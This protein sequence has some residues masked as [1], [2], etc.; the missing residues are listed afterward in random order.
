[1]TDR[2]QFEAMLEALINEDQETAKEIF[3][4][5]VVGKSRE[6]YESLLAT[7]FAEE[8][9][10]DEADIEMDDES[11][12]DS[13][14]EDFESDDSDEFDIESDEESDEDSDEDEFASKDELMDLEQALAELKAD[15]AQWMDKEEAE[16]ADH[17]GIHDLGGD[18]VEDS[19]D[20]DE[21]GLDEFQQFMEYVTKV[22]LPPHGDNGQQTKSVFN[23]NKYADMGGTSANIAAGGQADTKGTKG[24]LVDPSTDDLSGGNVNVPGSKNASKLSNVKQGHGAE[25]KGAAEPKVNDRSPIKGR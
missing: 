25:R 6:I 21:A 5:I 11:S 4:N 9:E 8:V 7:D 12:E 24:G 18:D 19:S 20:E 23:K 3:H 1:M 17:P 2:S 14:P 10:D 16:E 15:F 13:E 22:S